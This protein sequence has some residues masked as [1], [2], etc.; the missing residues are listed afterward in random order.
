MPDITN[1][2]VR[3]FAAAVG[4]GGLGLIAF[5]VTTGIAGAQEPDEVAAAIEDLT[6][7]ID[8]GWLL[9]AGTLVLFMQAGFA[10]VEAGFIRSKNVTN[11]LMK[12]ILDVSLGAIAYW[13][14]GF[15]LAYGTTEFIDIRFFGGGDFFPG[16][17]D[18]DYATW[19]FQFV[20]AA[21][22]ATIVSGAMAERT[23]F[24]AYL[25]YTVAI[26]AVV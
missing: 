18:F 24:R 16:G 12:N 10:L 2:H 6:S 3:R 26:T 14:V 25:L 5:A 23:Q 11:I 17:V 8:I 7:A 21:T 13:A 20:F 19:Y 4:L 22:A 15:G 1:R 9:V